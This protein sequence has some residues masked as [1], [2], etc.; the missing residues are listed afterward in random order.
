MSE[1]DITITPEAVPSSTMGFLGS[2]GLHE[3]IRYFAASAAALVVDVVVLWFLTS[4]IGLSY[5]YSGAIAFV[6]GLTM[7]YVLSIFWVF[8]KR[9]LADWRAEFLVF[10]VIG[11]VGLGLNELILW[12]LTGYFGW[13]YLVSKAASV[14]VVFSWNFGARKRFLF[15]H[16]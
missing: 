8:D 2:E 1:P 14:L 11:I 12:V 16:G 4:V 15:R 5:L 13:F 6:L 10:A 7:V 9:A 3:F